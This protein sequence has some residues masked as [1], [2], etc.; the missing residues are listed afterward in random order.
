LGD[1]FF[2]YITFL[3]DGWFV[4][5]FIG[6]IFLFRSKFQ[7][8]VIGLSVLLTFICVQLLKHFLFSSMSRPLTYFDG[9]ESIVSVDGIELHAFNSFPSGHAAQA[10]SIA[11]ALALM[12]ENKKWSPVFFLTALVV[13]LSRVYLAQHF[14]IDTYFGA[15]LASFVTFFTYFWISNY[16]SFATNDRLKKGLLL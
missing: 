6:L 9:R 1:I 5:P 14:L 15:L 12:S 7:A 4:I 10:F 13:A 3:G 2:K 11:M 8:L 16:T